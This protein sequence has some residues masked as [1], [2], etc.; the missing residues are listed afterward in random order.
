MSTANETPVDP[1]AAAAPT[2]PVEVETAPSSAP[3]EPTL[4]DAGKDALKAERTARR[5]AEKQ[6]NELAARIRE[7]EDRDKSELE[8]LTEAAANAKAEAAA[9]RAE[10]LR[11]KVAAELELPADLH[12]FLTGNDEDELRSKA[13]KL[14]AATGA[15]DPRRMKPDPAQGATPQPGSGP[16]QLAEADLASM[17]VDQIVAAKKAGRLN[18]LLGIK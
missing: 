6:A 13:E 4:G 17:S 11:L 5:Q 2:D 12:E 3:A 14:K 18:A 1:Q 8:K 15:G 7:F 10:M 9:A 16:D